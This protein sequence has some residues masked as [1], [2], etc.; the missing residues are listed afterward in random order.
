MKRKEKRTRG[1]DLEGRIGKKETSR[2]G[3]NRNERG[4]T[5]QDKK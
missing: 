3:K 5:K 4:Q 2:N 1:G